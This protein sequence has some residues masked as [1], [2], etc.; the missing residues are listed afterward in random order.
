[1]GDADYW[2]DAPYDGGNYYKRSHRRH[3]HEFTGS[4]MFA[5]RGPERHNH[6][7]A[8]VSSPA[9]PIHG[10][11]IHIVSTRT[12][13]VDGHYHKIRV[14]TSGAIDVGYGK[15][16]HL[17]YGTTSFDDGHYHRF[18]FASLVE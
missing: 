6:R 9:I 13:F 5:G 10:D 18:R 17:I 11:H 16:V 15:H 7:V 3:V 14:R 8:G 12:D 2:Y 4:V 1:M